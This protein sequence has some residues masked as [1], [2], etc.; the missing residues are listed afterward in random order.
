MQRT[1]IY[2]TPKEA[3][4]IARIASETKRSQS[5]VIREAI[6]RYLLRS[7]TPDRLQ[8]LRESSGMWKNRNIDLREIRADFDR[9]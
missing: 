6:D 9:F 7:D 5:E 2:L 1:Q 8:G 3:R 4:G